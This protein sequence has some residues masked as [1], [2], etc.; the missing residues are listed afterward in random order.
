MDQENTGREG[1]NVITASVVL[2]NTPAR[3]AETILKSFAPSPE[4]KLFFIDNS[5]SSCGELSFLKEH[6]NVEYIFTGANLGYGKANNIGIERAITEGADYHVVLNPDLQFEPAVLDALTAY[7]DS[8][9]DVVYMLPEVLS[10]EGEV[11]RLCKLLPTPADLIFRRFFPQRGVFAQSNDRYTLADSGYDRIIDPPCLSGCF[12]F[13]RVGALEEHK[14]RFDERF[15]M[16]CEDFD[17]IRRLHRVGRTIYYPAVHIVHRESKASY[18][19]GKMLA[20]H[21]VSACRYFN[22]YG[23]FRDPERDQMN[24]K[25]LDELEKA[26][27]GT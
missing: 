5:P 20:A 14:L 18:K 27:G 17:L 11:Q 16:Y 9:P 3:E 23:W 10:E 2:Y 24:R 7:A 15:F 21:I 6:G 12:M 22:K 25:I 26:G 4:R 1:V 13:M 8:N 19:N